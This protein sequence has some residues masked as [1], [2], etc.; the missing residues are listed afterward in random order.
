MTPLMQFAMQEESENNIF[1]DI[2][3]KNKKI[4]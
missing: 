3:I 1:S 4:I 2:A